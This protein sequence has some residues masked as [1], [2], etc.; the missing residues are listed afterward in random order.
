MFQPGM[1]HLSLDDND[2]LS[3]SERQ[4]RLPQLKF[5]LCSSISCFNHLSSSLFVELPWIAPSDLSVADTPVLDVTGLCCSRQMTATTYSPNSLT[6]SLQSWYCVG[7]ISSRRPNSEIAT[8][9]SIPA[10]MILSVGPGFHFL[11]HSRNSCTKS[12]LE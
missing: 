1:R 6:A 8:L 9:P 2:S 11:L 10:A 4:R 7:L 12:R 5:I 3:C